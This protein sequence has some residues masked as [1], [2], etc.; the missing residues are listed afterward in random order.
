MKKMMKKALALVLTLCTVL[1]LCVP[2]ASAAET[3][4][5]VFPEWSKPVNLGEILMG[6]L[7]TREH[8]VMFERDGKQFLLINSRAGTVY[9]FKLSD[10]LEGADNKGTWIEESFSSGSAA[11]SIVQ[12]SKGVIYMAVGDIMAYDPASKAHWK[13]PLPEGGIT[14]GLAVDEEDNLYAARG[15]SI[16]K[17]DTE[18]YTSEIIYTTDDISYPSTV[19]AGGGYLYVPGKRTGGTVGMA[20]HKVDPK[21]G[22][23]VDEI[24]YDKSSTLYY[25]SYVDGVLFGGH[26]GNVPDGMIAFDGATMEK[27]DVGPDNWIMGL[28]TDPDENGKCYFQVSGG[29]VWQYDPKTRTAERAEGL[30]AW[31]T[32]LRIK[33]PYIT[34]NNFEGIS[35]KC[36]VT[37]AS[38]G[39]TPAILSLEG[40]GFA[41]MPLLVE[42]GVSPSQTRSITAGIPGLMVNDPE[43]FEMEPVPPAGEVAVYI[44]G[45]LSGQIAR[46]SPDMEEEDRAE[47]RVFHQG[48]A[49]TDSM[50]T[51]KNKL[52]GGSY[53]GGYLWEYDPATGNFRDLID[54]MLDEHY[55]ARVHDLA[56]GD[57]KIFFST[58]PYT[59]ALGGC[60]GWYD[61]AEDKWTFM[62]R[63][64]VKDQ[65]LISIYYDETTDLLY[66]ASST[67]G[68]SKSEKKA[69]EAVI[70]V[71]DVAA[72]KKLGEFSVR[73]GVNPDS[74]MVFDLEAGATVPEYISCVTQDPSTGKFWGIVSNTVFSFE[75][76]KASNRMKIHEE[77][78][79]SGYTNLDKGR[80][81][82]AGSLQWFERPLLFDGNGYMYASFEAVGYLQRLEVANPKNHVQMSKTTG[83]MA[84]GSD[85]NL[86]LGSGDFLYKIALNRPDIVKA[87]IDGTEPKDKEGVAEMRLAY[88]ALTDEEKALISE[89]YYKDLVALEGA[90]TIFRQVA[91]EKVDKLIDSIGAVTV[92]SQGGILAARNAYEG[93]DQQEKAMVTLYD[94]LVAAE[95]AYAAISAKTAYGQ[96]KD[97]T[98]SFSLG[99]NPR[100]VGVDFKEIKYGHI[101]DSIWE[102]A[103]GSGKWNQGARVQ[104][105]F[106]S[107]GEGYLGV[108]VMI[109][110]A[111]LYDLTASTQEYASGGIGAVYMFPTAGLD[112][113]TLYAQVKDEVTACKVG[114]EHYIGTVDYTVTEIQSVGQWYCDTPGEYILAFGRRETRGGDYARLNSLTFSK[115]NPVTDPM[116]EMAKSRINAIGKVTKNS[117][118]AINEARITFDALS[119]AQ[120]ELIYAPQLERAEAQYKE[121]QASNTDSADAAAIALVQIQIDAIGEVT[122]GSGPAIRMAREAFDALSKKLQ[123]KVANAK[124]LTDAEAAY[125]A[126]TANTGD[127][128]DGSMT[129]LI[130]VIVIVVLAAAGAV[131]A[132]ILGKKK[133][134]TSAEKETD[135][136][137]T[138][139][140]SE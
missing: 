89:K 48:H 13:I 95:Q 62:E 24:I 91:A 68:G 85:G 17:V 52:Y 43:D 128:S 133:K 59:G 101:T 21:T 107:T 121:I 16:I 136:S 38:G 79:I 83:K 19:A 140:P 46:Y 50:I 127:E 8:A 105:S 20:I 12:D 1:S 97:R 32:N 22:Q 113:E 132:I 139:A 110:E 66:A 26:S 30:V 53:S 134:A 27:V 125:A 82:T 75:Y 3:E 118:E 7:S 14:Y 120:K 94:D 34:V 116:V 71:Y 39:A 74:D 122:A 100:A 90:V 92:T 10:Y 57:D 47:S 15:H 4:D 23:K 61:L 76:N 42:E 130:V 93:L 37:V 18:Y 111:G 104:M 102:Y 35:G 33:N 41:S 28:V 86:Y 56:A 55:Q 58:V 126:L 77:V 54:G 9:I 65:I 25:L 78:A 108:R 112:D 131:V 129:T 72:Q 81:P 98:V 88:N 96:P 44:G 45:Y 137:V 6:E 40:K 135:S 36:M 114:S 11:H 63:D 103:C 119:E 117:G 73:A 49:Q 109:V 70:M 69:T 84:L 115:Q 64:I 106:G 67:A 138:D 51:Y 5:Y 2:F 29:G 99:A 123:K 60:L 124:K 80:Y 31:S 87:M